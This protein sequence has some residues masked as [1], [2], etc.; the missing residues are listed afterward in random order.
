VAIN[1]A[2]KLKIS[3]PWAKPLRRKFDFREVFCLLRNALGDSGQGHAGPLPC[4]A[5]KRNQ[6]DP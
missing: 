4:V 6:I 3:G 1:G 5:A 2:S